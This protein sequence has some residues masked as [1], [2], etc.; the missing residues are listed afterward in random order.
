MKN[1][2]IVLY[3]YTFMADI[4][5]NVTENEAKEKAIECLKEEFPDD[6]FPLKGN[7]NGKDFIA[8]KHEDLIDSIDIYIDEDDLECSNCYNWAEDTLSKVS[9][10]NCCENYS[11]FEKCK[12]EYTLADLG[13]NWW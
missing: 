5:E 3:K 10:C 1:D 9:A 2:Y 11:M 7:D 12:E 13:N 4:F 6:A 8:Y